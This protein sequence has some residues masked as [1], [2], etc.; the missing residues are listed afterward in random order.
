MVEDALDRQKGEYAQYE[1]PV[2]TPTLSRT[3]GAEAERINPGHASNHR[4]DSASYVFHIYQGSGRTVLDTG[5]II[6]WN[7]CDTF[8]I[9][10]WVGFRHENSSHT[11]AYLF[12]FTE[13]PAL[14]ALGMWRCAK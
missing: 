7:A 10:A 9:P 11:V 5:K 13:K 14:T 2:N 4:Q 8:V 1:Y 6:E 12:S 3:L